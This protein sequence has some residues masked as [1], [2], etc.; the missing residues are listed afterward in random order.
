[1]VTGPRVALRCRPSAPNVRR[2]G[3]GHHRVPAPGGRADLA[4]AGVAALL[5][6]AAGTTGWWL[7]THGA[8]V[9]AD[10]PPLFA[11][12]GPHLGYG[13]PP[14]V[15]IAALVLRFGPALA[16]RW[17]WRRLLAGSYLG[18]ISWT[19]ALSLVDSLHGGVSIKL[20]EP[21]E[22]LPE[23]WRITDAAAALRGFAGRIVDYQPGSWN[24]QVA[25]HPPGA[26]LAFVALDRIGLGGGT[27]AGLVCLAAGAS[28][29]VSVPVTLHALGAPQAA[30][31]AVPFLV[32]F[33]GAVWVGVSADALFA[34]VAAAGIA[35]VAT[36]CAARGARADLASLGGGL[37]LGAALFLSYGLV[38]LAPLVLAVAVASGRIRPL[39]AAAAGVAAV[40]AAFAAGGFWWY[41]G[42]RLLVV[43]Y[44]QGIAEHRAYGYWVW[45][46]LACLVL[47][48]GVAAAPVL[49]RTAAGW[50]GYRSGAVPPAWRDPVLLLVSAA[51]VAV[52]AATLSGLSKAE[53]ERIWLPFAV[54]LPT[55]AS[56]LPARTHRGWLAAGAGT[57]LAVNHLLLTVW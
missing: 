48:A 52:L 10:A 40:T 5:V 36:G 53:V 24:I 57:A 26:L 7:N 50:L 49:R 44:H 30:R 13:T 33:P 45:A 56:L 14:A 12:W 17:P 43:R 2:M 11:R 55:G 3:T 34:G 16:A 9:V 18:A 54:W 4:A 46:D 28:V 29:A 15:A 31:T 27:A 1:M 42:Y 39:L 35:L 20:T 22:Y 51:A 25:G 8:P 37:L 32:L 47:C 41:T 21:T 6:L 23:A 19:L 38:L